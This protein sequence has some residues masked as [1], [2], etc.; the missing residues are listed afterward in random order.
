M[1][2]L[3]GF[4][5]SKNKAVGD[6]IELINDLECASERKFKL[7]HEEP[8]DMKA[9]AAEY[10]YIGMV[11]G[12]INELIQT[13]LPKGLRKVLI[14]PG[15]LEDLQRSANMLAALEAGGVDNWEWYH[16]SL[17][18]FYK[19]EEKELEKIEPQFDPWS[20]DNADVHSK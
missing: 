16:E 3:K 8:S 13:A 17:K 15:I 9:M 12:Q 2:E 18:D 5:G 10:A 1:S 7:E 11:I 14:H 4:E 19:E 6:L 20:V